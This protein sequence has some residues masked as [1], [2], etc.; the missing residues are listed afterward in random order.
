MV[1]L[2]DGKQYT[3]YHNYTIERYPISKYV[4][5]LSFLQTEMICIFEVG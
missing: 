3:L 2:F 1:S 4:F 5:E